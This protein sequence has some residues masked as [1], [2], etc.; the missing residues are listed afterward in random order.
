MK[1]FLQLVLISGI[2]LSFSGLTK[3]QT[4]SVTFKVDMSKETV[5]GNGVHIAGS[6]Q[7]EAGYAEDWDPAATSLS[8][9]DNDNI[10]E[11]TL[12]IPQGNYE[13]KFVNGNTWDGGE[14]PPGECTV[15]SH[16]NREISIYNDMNLPAVH[17]D[18]C[19]AKLHF[20]VNMRNQEISSHGVHVMGNFQ[21]SAGYAENWDPTAIE[22]HDSND[23]STYEVEVKVAPGDYNYLFVNGNTSSEAESLPDSCT[24]ESNNGERARTITA[25]PGGNDPKAYCF[26]SCNICFP[27]VSSNYDTY[28][29]NETVFYEI[30]VRSFNDSDGDGVGDFQGI[31]EKLDYLN[32]GDSTTNSDLGVEGIWLMPFNASPSYHGYDITDYYATNPDYGSIQDLEKL[33][34]EAHKRGIKVIMDFVM[35][36]SSDQHSWFTKSANNTDGFRDWYTW[37][38]S[39]LGSNW[40]QKNGSYYFGIFWSGMPD[41]N[42]RNSDVKNKMFDIADFWLNKGL[43]GFRLDAIKFLY[44]NNTGNND[45]QQTLSILE[46]FKNEYT[47]TKPKAFTVG[48]V[49]SSTSEITPYVD[50][51]RLDICFEFNL[52]TSIIDA[53]NNNNP[54]QIENKMEEVT[55][56]YPR[57]QYGTFLTNHDQDRAFSRFSSDMQ[58]MKQAASI[59]L[60]MP[61]VP[62]V[63][64]GEEVGMTGTGDHINIR[65]PMQ[66]N[67]NSNAGFSSSTPWTDLGNNYQTNN[68]ADMEGESA[69]LL[70]NYKKFIHLRNSNEALQKGYYADIETTNSQMLSFARIYKDQ[71]VIVLSNFGTKAE[72]VD[73]SLDYSALSAG[74]YKATDLLSNDSIDTVS[75]NANGG[76]GSWSLNDKTINQRDTRVIALSNSAISDTTD[77]NDTTGTFI[78]EP[79]NYQERLKLFPNPANNHFKVKL[80]NTGH[81]DKTINVYSL[82]GEKIYQNRTSKT[83]H[84]IPTADWEPGIYLIRVRTDKSVKTGRIL[85]K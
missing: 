83:Q 54:D 1:K 5:S 2:I 31:I 46:E 55:E 61:G 53:V 64:Y 23:D 3:G 30:F 34:E 41:L 75:V 68:V 57:L 50:K 9:S 11:T 24:V 84:T 82:P 27:S 49:W 7:T 60:T 17:F 28:W 8:D 45:T 37:Q 69:S 4:Y 81:G 48:E 25:K 71:A 18:S 33:I 10:Y 26:N 38:S 15:G 39:D 42:Y 79:G 40:H 85:I 72:S 77:N 73:I 36:H 66:W 6:F 56:V 22:M 47:S 16:N 65:R 29:W 74:T 13:Y 44:E 70:E 78:S 67:G 14:N 52:A 35:N 43:D 63:Y 21:Q 58:K 76:F 19:Y 59:Y 62:F 12:N 51:E 80:D 32:D 20:K